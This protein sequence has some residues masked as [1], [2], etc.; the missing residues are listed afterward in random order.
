MQEEAARKEAKNA[1]KLEKEQATVKAKA[2]KEELKKLK[3]QKK[4]LK[5]Q[6]KQDGKTTKKAKP[7]EKQ[8]SLDASLKTAP[9][10]IKLEEA[11]TIGKRKG[12]PQTAESLAS[13]AT[14]TP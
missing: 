13:I 9:S 14:E 1:K 6:A 3:E 5:Q 4:L 8:M 2:E 7:D 12:A 11:A 10:A